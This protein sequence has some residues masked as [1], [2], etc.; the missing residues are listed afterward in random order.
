MKTP[1]KTPR[2]PIQV[3]RRLG[4]HPITTKKGKKGYSR[5]K[6]K[7]ETGLVITEEASS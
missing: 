2:I 4:S 6:I 5:E 1:K 3:L 7:K